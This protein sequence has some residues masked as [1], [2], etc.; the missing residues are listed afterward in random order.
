MRVEVTFRHTQTQAVKVV[1]VRARTVA[2]GL[3]GARV[4]FYTE[5]DDRKKYLEWGVQLVRKVEE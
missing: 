4:M 1:T 3:A 5:L 2:E